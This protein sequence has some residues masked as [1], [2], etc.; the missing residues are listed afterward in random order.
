MIIWVKDFGRTKGGELVSLYTLENSKR[1][2]VQAI[3]YGAAV[4]SAV[5][6]KRDESF[7]DIVLGYDDIGSYENQKSRIGAVV[8][9]AA[10]RVKNGEVVLDATKYALTANDGAD[11]ELGGAEGF[12][13]KIWSAEVLDG[14]LVMSCVSPDGDEGYPGTLQ[15]SVKYYLDDDDA[16]TV[17]YE[18][19]T[20]KTTLCNMSNRLFFNLDGHDS[21]A[22]ND[23]RIAIDVGSLISLNDGLSLT[24]GLSDF[25]TLNIAEPQDGSVK[26]VACAYSP[27]SG[28][29]LIISSNMPGVSLYDGLDIEDS[30][31][32]KNG[33]VYNKRGGFCLAPQYLSLDQCVLTSDKTYK[34]EIV[35]HFS[36]I[37]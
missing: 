16:F 25:K 24:G 1:T 35:Y 28:V 14:A 4:V 37:K 32:G 15:A 23:Q 6:P 7:V 11:H 19:Q 12:D 36:V 21:D 8:G 13:K 22:I 17:S 29:E 5:V 2:R 34:S 27:A 18:A 20:D 10:N 30:S 33:A 31:V 3:N 26:K 9:R